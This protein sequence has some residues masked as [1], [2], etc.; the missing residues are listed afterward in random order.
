MK[1]KFCG[2]A[3][4]VTGSAHLITLDNGYKILLDCGLYQGRNKSMQD[5]NTSWLFKPS[6]IDCLILSH[7][8]IDHCGRIPKL[9]KD[10]FRGTIHCTHATRSLC[11]I[12]L[13]DSA[14]IQVRDAEY[15]N[16]RQ[17][18]KKKRKRKALREPLYDGDDVRESMELYQ[19]YSYDQWFKVHPDVEVLFRD[20]GH[21]L[22]SASVTLKIKE[23][24]KIT[25]VGFTGDIGRPTDRYFV[26]PCQCPK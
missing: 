15:F 22:G 23:K 14:K 21:I 16:K 25:H 13:L 10:G 1:I 5:F 26:I 24:G 8:H 12:M 9:V 6:E 3:Q 2:A 17:L 11:S 7:A 4:Q 20:M 18:R 19:S